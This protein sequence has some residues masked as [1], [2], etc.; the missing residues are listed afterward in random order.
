MPDSDAY[1]K[2]AEECRELAAASKYPDFRE[3][4]ERMAREWLELARDA[5]LHDL[6]KQDGEGT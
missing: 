4:Y 6:R 2:R 5:E 3:Q 1:R